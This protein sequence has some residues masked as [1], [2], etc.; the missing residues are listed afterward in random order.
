MY[1]LITFQVGI[2][3]PAK[4]LLEMR[5]LEVMRFADNNTT[6]PSLQLREISLSV[7]FCIIESVNCL[8]ACYVQMLLDDLF[9]NKKSISTV[10]LLNKDLTIGSVQV[11]KSMKSKNILKKWF[12]K[13]SI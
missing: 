9:L 4:Q 10:I 2:I 1:I 11:R 3:T 6:R 13:V 8:Q 5:A 12:G 7:F